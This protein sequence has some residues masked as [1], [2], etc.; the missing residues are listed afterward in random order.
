MTAKVS[1]PIAVPDMQPTVESMYQGIIRLKEGYENL[2]R[3]RG[4]PSRWPV[5]FQDLIDMEVITQE[6]M[7][8]QLRRRR[9]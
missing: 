1:R 9:V 3:Q 6:Q 7:N 5:T 2:S 4:E 8:E